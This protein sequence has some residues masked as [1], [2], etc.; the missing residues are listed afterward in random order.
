MT[1][2]PRFRVPA[3]SAPTADSF[4]NLSA[5][6]GYGSGSVA[7]ASSY[8]GNPITRNRGLLDK[9]YRGSWLVGAAV[10]APA[11]DMT[12][13]GIDL[14]S[15]LDP[16]VVDAIKDAMQRLAIWPALCDTI[17]WARLYGGAIAVMM[18]DGQR[19]DQ[20]LRIETIGKGQFKG[21]AV[22]DRW[23]ADPTVSE[24]VRE[25]G[26]DLGKPLFYR[27]N[28]GASFLSG[29]RIHHSRVI[30]MEGNP[31]PH[32]ERQA[33]MGWGQS[34]IERVVD[35]LTA[36][37]STTVGASQLVYRS[38][39]R[40]LKVDGLRDII[41]AGG[42]ALEGFTRQVEMIRAMQTNEGLTVIDAKDEMSA[43]SYGFSGLSDLM[44]QF[45]QQ[46]SGAVNVPMVRL[47]GQ[48]PTGLNTSGEADVRT[49]Y[50]QIKRRQETDL[51]GPVGKVLRA[52]HHSEIGPLEEGA[53]LGFTFNPLWQMSDAEK[54][55]IAGKVAT[56]VGAAVEGGIIDR[57]TA[58]REL[59]QSSDITGVFT[60]IT[61]DAI[62]D[63]ESA[64][65]PPGIEGLD[66][67]GEGLLKAAAGEAK[68]R[69]AAVA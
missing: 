4:Q 62:E 66:L 46:L 59:K 30:R 48:T 44:V 39:L 33:E 43:M 21:L 7:S 18:V 58:M 1:D 20:P 60:N 61:P 14:T 34:V 6:L 42:K 26:P 45:A 10:D 12:R 37:D 35:R 27:V 67:D 15:S 11:E 69:I 29:E 51:R 40:M 65:V 31:L 57:P 3:I 53:D 55:E 52:I 22:L 63:A 32:W 54:A 8:V 23:T 28:S 13:E 50:D 16:Q 9:M 19:Y 5:R 41:A 47:F 68:P 2:K 24:P 64:L 56:A 17:R 38:H 49:Y 36:F 25:P